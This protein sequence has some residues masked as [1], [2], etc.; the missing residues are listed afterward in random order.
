LE[1]FVNSTIHDQHIEP[2]SAWVGRDIAGKD[3]LTV[4]LTPAQG[5]ALRELLSRFERDGL[6]LGDIRRAHC[7]HPE[8][9]EVLARVLREVQVG[10]GIVILRGVPTDRP[11]QQVARMLWAIGTHLGMAV[12]QN[13]SGSLMGYVRD[14]T[15]KG[16]AES[17]RG[18]RSR[19]ELAVHNDFAAIVGLMCVRPAASGGE[20]QFVSAL[21]IHNEF[22]ANR[23]DLLP[24]LYEG[25]HHHRLGEQAPGLAAI[26][27]FKVPTFCNIDGKVSVFR[28]WDTMTIAARE[29]G[30]PLTPQQAEADAYFDE[31]ARRIQ[32]ECR[33]DAGE[34]ALLN[35]YTVLHS[36]NQFIDAEEEERKR[37]MLRLWL[38]VPGGRPVPREF[39]LYENAGGNPG[40]DVRK[41]AV[42]TA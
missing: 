36:R 20:S 39:N 1:E 41:T 16:Q 30:V 40:I 33:L 35:N 34:V 31:T 28:N 19:R 5:N 23:P 25:F 4:S 32:F 21:A 10:R 38:D 37:L 27:P 18:Y 29:S 9:D 17:V 8:L 3:D 11:V 2:P 15:P 22:L 12:S 42:Q 24:V 6:D 26:T 7:G 14:E 13:S